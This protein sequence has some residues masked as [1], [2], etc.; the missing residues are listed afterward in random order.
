MWNPL[1]MVSGAA[2]YL[3]NKVF[4]TGNRDQVNA[5]Q[6]QLDDIYGKA[7]ST[8][9]ANRA[10]YDEYLGKM[11]GMYGTGAEQYDTARQNLADAIAN[12][13]DFTYNGK[14][15]DFLDPAR[16]QRVDAAMNAINASASSGGNRFSS[17]YLDK[18][19]AKSQAMASEEWAKSYDRMMRDRAAQLQQ[20]QTGQSRINNLGTLANLYGQ[21]R[22]QLGNA[23]GD[24]YSAM[25]NQN[26][27]NLET[28]SDLTSNK[29]NLEASKTNGMGQLLGGAAK[30]AGAIFG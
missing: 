27:A 13:K 18:L 19:N 22:T 21:D 14:T 8:S 30:I 16:Q 29:A 28:Y 20:W 7:E 9:E 11:Q 1:D 6:D 23:I 17:N 25:A 15:E 3:G 24:Y 12:Y 4:G 5:A 2:D 10:L 26:N